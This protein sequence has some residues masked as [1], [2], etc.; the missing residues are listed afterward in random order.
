VRV[1]AASGVT[2]WR[3]HDLRRTARTGLSRLGV[4]PAHAEAALN[5]VSHRTP[6]E[7]IYDH[8]DYRPEILA[9]LRLWQGH[10]AGLVGATAEAVA[11]A[12]LRGALGA[13][14]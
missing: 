7:K 5:H 2:G 6:L 8:H 13:E 12:E 9:A 10:V 3:W 11:L 1:D 14:A 4:P